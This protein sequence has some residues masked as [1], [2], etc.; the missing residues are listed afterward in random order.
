MAIPWG[1]IINAGAQIGSAY[2]ASK[3]QGRA[4][5]ATINQ[6]QDQGAQNAYATDKSLD[7]EALVRAYGAELDRATGILKEQEAR[8]AAPGQRASNSVRGDILANVQDVGVSAPAG[9]NVTSFS[10]GLRPSLLSGNSR[11]LGAQMSK[12]ALLDALDG[13]D[14]T[15]FSDLTPVDLSSITGRTAPAQ[16]GL[17]QASGIDKVMEQIGLWGG[18]AGAGLNAMG[19]PQR[20]QQAAQ[21]IAGQLATNP[22]RGLGNVVG[23][24][25]SNPTWG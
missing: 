12:E 10:G 7:L 5:E 22:Y 15:P 23:T 19:Q 14:A 13:K 16:T 8:L 17:P 1:E 21:T 24:Q 11:A 20:Q 6:R 3:A 25:V 18:L 9:V 4:A 2:A